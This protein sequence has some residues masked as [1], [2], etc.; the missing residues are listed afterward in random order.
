VPMTVKERR[1]LPHAARHGI[2]TEILEDRACQETIDAAFAVHAA[3]GASHA[4]TTYLNALAVEIA[5]R[6]LVAHRRPSFSVVYRGKVV[7]AFDGDLLVEERVLV[8][9]TADRTLTDDH[10]SDAI[11]GLVAGGVKVGL[12]FNFGVGDLRFARI[13]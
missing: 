10:K 3:L 13:L 4:A 12:A 2:S 6:G 8:Q 5:A 1:L 9:V 11:R 7:G